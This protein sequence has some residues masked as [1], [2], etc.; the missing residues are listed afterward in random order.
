MTSGVRTRQEFLTMTRQAR[1]FVALAFILLSG[2]GCMTCCHSGYNLAHEVGPECELPT[3]QRNGV[4][5]FAMSSFN[6]VSVFA[7]DGLREQ[8]NRQGFAKVATGQTIHSWW[9]AREMRRIREAEPDAQFVVVGFESAGIVAVRLADKMA[10]EGLAVGG[11]VV[12]DSAGNVPA[13]AQ[14]LR[15]L[16]VGNVQGVMPGLAETIP[17]EN[18]ASHGLA[19]D[20][21]TVEAVGQLLNAAASAVPIPPVVEIAEWSY[22]HAPPMREP[23]DPARAPEWAFLFD[24]YAAATVQQRPAPTPTPLPAPPVVPNGGMLRSAI[25]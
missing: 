15:V 4:Y 23:G 24:Q 7:L 14:G 2:S 3:C 11:V 13:S 6:P 1:Q 25:R 20:A 16:A 10:A 5:V 19:A 22:P 17:V 18:V 12:I 8:L 9:M 21:R